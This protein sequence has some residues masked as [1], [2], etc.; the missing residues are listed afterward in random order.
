MG[1]LYFWD[2]LYSQSLYIYD[3]LFTAYS[4]ETSYNTVNAYSSI[5]F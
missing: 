2:T 3:R 5:S 1:I 4:N